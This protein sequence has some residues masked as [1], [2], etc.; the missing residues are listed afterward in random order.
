MVVRAGILAF[1]HSALLA[2]VLLAGCAL[3]EPS[4]NRAFVARKSGEIQAVATRAD[5][6]IT[7]VDENWMWGEDREREN[8]AYRMTMSGEPTAADQ[9]LFDNYRAYHYCAEPSPDVGQDV[10][11]R[12]TAGLS[13]GDIQVTA[14]LDA[15]SSI[16]ALFRRSQGVQLFRDGLFALCQA[17]HNG[18]VGAEEYAG[19]IA[20][21]IERASYLIALEIA[22]SP[23]G[24]ARDTRDI[25][26][27]IRSALTPLAPKPG[28]ALPP[29]DMVTVSL[30]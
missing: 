29:S 14:G 13:R 18:A 25:S 19:F 11:S 26:E 6:R 16:E 27:I 21:L 24:K 2:G 17:H 28:R 8:V 20:S 7:F 15:D 23:A 3:T 9:Q 1:A 30:P 5:H 10:L 12:L 22:L 4:S